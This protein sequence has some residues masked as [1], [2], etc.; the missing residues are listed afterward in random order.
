MLFN[1]YLLLVACYF[2]VVAHCYLLVKLFSLVEAL[3]RVF[4]SITHFTD[5]HVFGTLYHDLSQGDIYFEVGKF[6]FKGNYKI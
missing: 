1:C 4:T 2:F 6:M 3:V 5:N